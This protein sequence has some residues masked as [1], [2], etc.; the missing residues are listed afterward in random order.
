MQHP[1]LGV[2]PPQTLQLDAGM[3][4]IAGRQRRHHVVGGLNVAGM[5]EQVRLPTICRGPVFRAQ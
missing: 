5:E 3:I 4:G 2:E 1:M